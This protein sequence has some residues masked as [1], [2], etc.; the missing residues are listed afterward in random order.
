MAVTYN[1]LQLLNEPQIMKFFIKSLI[2]LLIVASVVYSLAVFPIWDEPQIT[3]SDLLLPEVAAVSEAD[4]IYSALPIITNLIEPELQ[5]V[6]ELKQWNKQSADI[7]LV[8]SSSIV[9]T[10]DLVNNFELALKRPTF[11]CPDISVANFSTDMSLCSL[12]NLL[13]L[14]MVVSVHAKFHAAAGDTVKATQ[15]TTS[16][17]RFGNSIMTQK[18]P[19]VKDYVVGLSIMKIGFDTLEVIGLPPAPAE[20]L[21]RQFFPTNDSLISVLKYKYL[22]Q[23]TLF[24]SIAGQDVNTYL[25]QSKRSLNSLAD[26]TRSNIAA[27]TCE[28]TAGKELLVQ[29]I[30]HLRS[31]DSYTL[32]KPNA[33]GNMYIS[34]LFASEDKIAELYCEL[35][36]RLAET[37]GL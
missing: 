1:Y 17:L 21:R 5:I 9:T 4:N 27:S 37:R 16:L 36:S 23:K 3:D 31:T 13:D 32:I 28:N 14:A 26:L 2:L 34:A 11:Y 25:L 12:Y 7:T 8:A 10:T 19:L 35:E 22:Y 20:A 30:A 18:Y 15:L 24:K 33:L 6:A 29:K